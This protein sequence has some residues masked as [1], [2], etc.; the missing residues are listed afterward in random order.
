MAEIKVIAKLKPMGKGFRLVDAEDVELN[1]KGVDEVINGKEDDI[2]HFRTWAEYENAKATIPAG[3]MF[4]V[5]EDNPENQIPKHNLLEGRDEAN[6]HPYT[7][8]EGLQAQLDK[9]TDVA[10][11][12]TL[13]SRMNQFAKL[14]EG[15]T[16]GDAELADIRVGADG[17]TYENAGEAVRGQVS[18]LKETIDTNVS[19]LKSDL[20][21]V[22]IPFELQVGRW[23][24]GYTYIDTSVKNFMSSNIMHLRKGDVVRFNNKKYICKIVTSVYGI[25]KSESENITS[26]YTFENDGDYIISFMRSD[27]GNIQASDLT[28]G[29]YINYNIN[30]RLSEI[31]TD[32]VTAKSNKIEMFKGRITG[33]NSEIDT[34]QTAWLTSYPVKLYKGEI[35]TFDQTKFVV[36]LGISENGKAQ[37]YENNDSSGRIVI[38]DTADYI[39]SM[40]KTNAAQMSDDDLNHANISTARLFENITDKF[41]SVDNPSSLNIITSSTNRVVPVAVGDRQRLSNKFEDDYNNPIQSVFGHEYLEHWYEAIYS[42]SNNVKVVLDG[43]SITE[44]YYPSTSEQDCFPNMRGWAIK[45]IMRVGNFPM[46]KL[47]VQN[48]GHG[49]RKTGEYVGNT[50]YGKPSVVSEYPNGYLDVSM[51]ENPDLLII[52]YG[53]NDADKTNDELHGLSIEQRLEVFKNN[54]E[55]ALKRIRGNEPVNGRPSYNKSAND[56]SIIICMPVVGGSRSSGRGFLLWNQYLRRIIIDLCRK[57]ECAFCDMSYRTYSH[58]TLLT[59]YWSVKE[60]NGKYGDIHPNK[61]S[62]A[63]T[64]SMLQD[65]V[66]PVCM[67]NYEIPN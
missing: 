35:V 63:Q 49:G 33:G 6:A 59:K 41:D 23:R 34:T 9:K 25:S 38:P 62:Q 15:S 3:A 54:M 19:D 1:G 31:N 39:I 32:I 53:M 43:D 30:D 16:A 37:I 47:S 51:N 36:K 48:N 5:D 44:G 66:Y 28:N 24:L 11:T 13:E 56:L 29:F 46:D 4:V 17:K 40:L 60:S 50:V 57:Y 64:M 20:K 67:W 65:L 52:A 58:D 10:K 45:K 61:Y 8:I 14:P 12:Q 22:N 7:A 21:Q 18:G 55:E 26:D 2:K 27:F 42:A